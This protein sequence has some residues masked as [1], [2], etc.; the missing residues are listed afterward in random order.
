MIN[1]IL[2]VKANIDTEVD[3]EKKTSKKF[4][5]KL[6]ITIQ[7]INKIITVVKIII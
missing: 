4:L 7:K 1:M 2:K 3:L 5:N 6:L